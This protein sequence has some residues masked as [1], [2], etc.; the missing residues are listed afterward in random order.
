MPDFYGQL[1]PNYHLIFRDWPAAITNQAD[2]LSGIIRAQWGGTVSSV[3][4]VSCRIGTKAIGLARMGFRVTASDLSATGMAR[5]EQET[6]SRGLKISYSVCDMREANLHHGGGFD[7][8]IS[9]DNSITHLLTDEDILRALEQMYACT[10]PDGGCLLTV[11]DY[12]QEERGIGLVKPCGVR[13]QDGKRH[14]IFQVW[15]FDGDHYDLSMYFV[16]DD[17]VAAVA[18][19]QI[20][21]SRYYAISPNKILRLMTQAGFVNVER[22]DGEFYQPVVVGTRPR[23]DLV[24]SPI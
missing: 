11:R 13:E 8:T 16:E 2:Q 6:K 17:G 5:A 23:Q 15:D 10:S 19:T 21:R 4:D 24:R 20:M 12:D 18:P 9:C 7:L 1:A 22:L 3:L 14:L